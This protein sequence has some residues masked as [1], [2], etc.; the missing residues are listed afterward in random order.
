ML[1]KRGAGPALTD[2]QAIFDH[3]DR[4]ASSHRAYHFP[5]ATS[6]RIAMSKACS[7][8][9]FLSRVFSFSVP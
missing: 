5:S 1:T 6:L 4:L 8:T 9:S 3:L 7:A 2:F